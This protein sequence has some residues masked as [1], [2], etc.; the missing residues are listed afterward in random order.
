[1]NR[2]QFLS[3][4]A[5]SAAPSFAQPAKPNIVFILADDLGYG[6]LGCYGQKEMA[7]PNLDKLA[8]SGI[9]FTQFYCGSTVCAPSR[10][11]LME[12]KHLGHARIRGN[13]RVDLLPED[14]TVAEV[15]KA[16]GYR[17][18]L[19]GKWG[20]GTAGNSGIPNR[21]GFDEFYGFLDQKHAHTQYPT[22][23]WENER[24]TFLD[25]NF[26]PPRTDY[27]QD[28][29]TN[30]S[31]AFL[32]R[33]KVGPFFLYVAYTTPHANNEL[34]KQT[35]NGMEIPGDHPYSSK[36]WPKPDRDFAGV[37][38]RLDRDVGTLLAKLKE[39]GIEQNTLVM[40]A[41]DNGPH[42]E[43]GNNPEFFDSNGPL[44][45]IK[46]D[47]YDG[48][49][50]TPFLASWPGTIQPG[51]VSDAVCAFWDILPTFA[52]VAGARSPSGIDGISFV[53]VLRGRP[54][55]PRE[56]LY[57]EFHEGGFSQAVRIGKWK[58]VRRR[59]RQAP[60]EIYDLSAD[61]GERKDL[62]QSQPELVK[63][64]AEIFR[65]AR[66]ESATFPVVDQG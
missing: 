55:P 12:G 10:S 66:T 49:I 53:P 35:G 54:M 13:A 4:V 19:I 28:V 11:A 60:I 36:P 5:A 18:G 7:T 44:R 59:N 17:T 23:L 34:T 52:E 25:G 26:G 42:R 24:E 48:G 8:A 62:A 56:Y 57:W 33:H 47:L 30:R 46:R 40:F 61:I 63:R 45:G 27:A 21:Q 37:V 1:M 39:L 43:G 50:R 15:L 3:T 51:Q 20:L 29:F 2:R 14:V 41:S 9:R 65:S 22:Q 38:A 32:E 64:V 16:A 31:L 58:G 6:D